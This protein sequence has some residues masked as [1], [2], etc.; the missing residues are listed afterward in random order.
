MNIYYSQFWKLRNPKSV[1]WQIQYLLRGDLLDGSL[2][3]FL[4]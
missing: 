4:L 1:C 3:L 2:F